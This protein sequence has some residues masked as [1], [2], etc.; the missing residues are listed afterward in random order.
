MLR[1]FS[2]YCLIFV[3]AA[4]V[5]PV[6]SIAQS[7]FVQ[8]KR[9][10]WSLTL[11]MNARTE[12]FGLNA[13]VGGVRS[14]TVDFGGLFGIA[15][16]AS[17]NMKAV[18]AYV[19]LYPVKQNERN[20]FSFGFSATIEQDFMSPQSDYSTYPGNYWGPGDLTHNETAITFG[21]QAN[22]QFQVSPEFAVQLSAGIGYADASLSDPG[23]RFIRKFGLSLIGYHDSG[24]SFV[25][26][27]MMSFA[28]G[29]TMYN[30][31]L[32]FVGLS[33]TNQIE[34]EQW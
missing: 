8:G 18:G 22:R 1:Q 13:L 20:P 31:S 4:L 23:A 30:V 28:G 29:M 5:M 15:S 32:T 10:G 16:G 33:R 27:P 19:G 24:S 2:I 34:K 3:I 9:N 6:S 25:V 14:G 21:G 7:E 26:T 12:F 11:E 17:T